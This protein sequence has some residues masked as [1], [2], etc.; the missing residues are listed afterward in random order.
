MNERPKTVE[1]KLRI[2]FDIAKRIEEKAAAQ[3]RWRNHVVIEE[4]AA[5]PALQA[6]KPIEESLEEMRAIVARHRAILD[7]IDL[8][9]KLLAAI[10]A[11]VNSR[12]GAQWAAI[13]AM[14]AARLAMQRLLS[15]S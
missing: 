10:D 12:G 15:E 13:E 5:I 1:F 14:R 7:R 11:V 6:C 2:P 9:E 8:N 3:G 4:L